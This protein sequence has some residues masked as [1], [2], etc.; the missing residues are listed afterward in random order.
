MDALA[1]YVD[2]RHLGIFAYLFAC[3]IGFPGAEEIALL[4]G[5]L[6]VHAQ[7]WTYGREPGLAWTAT[8]LVCLAGI[9]AGDATLF[10]LGRR[11]G[12]R[13]R[14][15]KPF[16]RLLRP[17]RMRRVREFFHRYGSGAIFIARFLPGIRA[18]TFFTAGWTGM[19][20]WRFLLWNGVAAVLSVPIGVWIGYFFGEHG[21]AMLRRID[22]TIGAVL[23]LAF[24]GFLLWRRI[25]ARR[26]PAAPAPPT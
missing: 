18:A 1:S 6:I 16:R 13:V 14:L 12:R 7:I 26:T 11:Y 21:K 4:W 19:A 24:G 3:G 20:T 23:L 9:V 17:R 22:L 2:W 8:V 5:G 25:R 15:L 10:W